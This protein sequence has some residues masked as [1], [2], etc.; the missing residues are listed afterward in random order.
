MSPLS[1][2]IADTLKSCKYEPRHTRIGNVLFPLYRFSRL[3]RP[4]ART[5]MRI[6]AG[7][8]FSSTW[9]RIL[10]TYHGVTVGPLS[11]GPALLDGSIPV[12]TV[13]GGY[14]SLAPGIQ[15]LRRNHPLGRPS[16]HPLFYNRGVGPLVED[17]IPS[18]S[19]NPLRIGSDVWI[20][21]NSIVCPG[22]KSIGDGAI[23][24]AGAVVTKDVPPCSIVGGNPAKV[25]RQRFTPEIAEAV[26][27]SRWWEFPVSHIVSHLALFLN[28]LTPGNLGDFLA[29]FPQGSEMGARRKSA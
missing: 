4:I 22:C 7:T 2:Q 27:A 17:T 19:S 6:E 5:L 21:L 14:C 11:Y 8:M 24:A 16:Q 28:D 23:I 18:V 20:G 12:G 9:R 29:A 15:F 26:L 1:T 10:S 13:V 3:R 25:I